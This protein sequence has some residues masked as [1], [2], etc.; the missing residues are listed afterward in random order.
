M[1]DALVL[2]LKA[3][4]FLTERTDVNSEGLQQEEEANLGNHGPS[5][6]LVDVMKYNRGKHRKEKV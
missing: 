2:L 3:E 5:S 6:H 1:Q 4:D